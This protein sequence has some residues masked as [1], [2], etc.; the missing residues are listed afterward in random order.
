[1]LKLVLVLVLCFLAYRVLRGLRRPSAP[2]VDGTG[3]AVDPSRAVEAEFTAADD[4]E[5]GAGDGVPR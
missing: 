5:D 1:M 3:R 4:D 2:E